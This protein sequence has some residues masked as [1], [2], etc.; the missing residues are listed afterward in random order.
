MIDN[1]GKI[2]NGI[3][4]FKRLMEAFLRNTKGTVSTLVDLNEILSLGI[5]INEYNNLYM[6]IVWMIC[7][8]SFCK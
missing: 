4:H 8:A 5:G 2:L 3:F 1:E 7:Y 6:H